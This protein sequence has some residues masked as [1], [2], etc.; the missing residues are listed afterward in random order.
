MVPRR[1]AHWTPSSSTARRSE[2]ALAD[3][4][5]CVRLRAICRLRR[6]VHRHGGLTDE[7]RRRGRG[8]QRFEF[9]RGP[10]I[11]RSLPYEVRIDDNQVFVSDSPRMR[12]SSPTRGVRGRRQRGD[13]RKRLVTGDERKTILDNRKSFAASHLRPFFVD[14]KRTHARLLFRLPAAATATGS[15]CLAMPPILLVTRLR[16]TPPAGAQVKPVWAGLVA[17]TGVASTTQALAFTVRSSPAHRSPA[18]R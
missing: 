1:S 2:R 5:N 9:D 12:R 14:A 16:S 15:W 11:L 4:R 13:R 10:A 8:R 18:A 7:R 3:P 17:T 6:A